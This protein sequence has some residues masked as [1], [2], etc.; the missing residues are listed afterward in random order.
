MGLSIS[1]SPSPN[2]CK[3]YAN[4]ALP[5]E[6]PIMAWQVDSTTSNALARLPTSASRN[7]LLSPLNIQRI[8]LSWGELEMDAILIDFAAADPLA[9]EVAEV[10]FL[11][12]V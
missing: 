7:R 4:Y 3:H 2:E 11:H 12:A 10:C 9:I 1:F 5:A 8:P 6:R